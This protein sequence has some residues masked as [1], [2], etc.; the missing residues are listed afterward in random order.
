V[1]KHLKLT[2]AVVIEATVNTW[3]LYDI[4]EP[5]RPT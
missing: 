2:D 3:M 5:P 1:D 4:V